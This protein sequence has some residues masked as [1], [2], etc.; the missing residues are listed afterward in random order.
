M[1]FADKFTVRLLILAQTGWLC[2]LA[3][4]QD[5]Y[6]AATDR[7]ALVALY[8]ATDG[9][10]WH[11]NTNWL[12]DK[13]LDGWQAVSTNSDGRVNGLSISSN[14]L[15]G[16]LP[17]E[18]GN[19]SEMDALMIYSTSLSGPLPTSLGNLSKMRPLIL[20]GNNLSGSIPP[21]LATSTHCFTWGS[22][23]TT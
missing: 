19:L 10:N 7:A 12:T 6:T 13:S 17:S 14:N 9:D 2:Q 16:S 5:S 4:A 11:R 23:R 1:T 15:N 22:S 8:N 18:L 20:G 21:A 3:L